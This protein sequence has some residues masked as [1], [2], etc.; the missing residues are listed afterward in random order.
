LPLPDEKVGA[1]DILVA[2]SV[3]VPVGG[4][5]YHADAS[6]P[7]LEVGA[8]DNAVSVEV[9][10]RRLGEKIFGLADPYVAHGVIAFIQARE[11]ELG[12]D[13]IEA[14]V[15]R[16]GKRPR[17][18]RVGKVA[19]VRTTGEQRGL[20]HVGADA[21][22]RDSSDEQVRRVGGEA[23]GDDILPAD[24]GLAA[25]GEV[26]LLAVECE[27]ELVLAGGVEQFQRE[28]AIG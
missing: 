13:G 21:V 11:L 19:D 6:P 4:G 26:S 24:I 15:A 20:H 5:P 1:V 14:L 17:E 8:V 10:R 9:A 7:P 2:V 3:A 12:D 22:A 23:V 25:D 28:R 27:V 16:G 18:I